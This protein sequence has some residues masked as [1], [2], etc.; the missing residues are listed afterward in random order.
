[1][2]ENMIKQ[3]MEKNL[4]GLYVTR[5]NENAIMDRIWENQKPHRK[6]SVGLVL[7]LVVMLAAVGALAAVLL[8]GKAF[9]GQI[10]APMATQTDSE[11]FTK[12]EVGRIIA[13][14]EENGVQLPDRIYEHYEKWGSEYKEELM[15]ALVKTELGF[16]PARWSLEDQHWYGQLLEECGLIE[17]SSNLLPG[18]GD[19]TEAYVENLAIQMITERLKPE[20]DLRDTTRYK[21]SMTYSLDTD[22]PYR[23]LKRWSVAYD[24][25][26][27]NGYY[28]FELLSNGLVVDLHRYG[29]GDTYQ[30][31]LSDWQLFED[32]QA[33]YGESMLDW[34]LEALEA[35][36]CAVAMGRGESIDDPGIYRVSNERFLLPGR[37]YTYMAEEEAIR[38]AREACGAEESLTPYVIYIG[39]GPSN[40]HWKISF[41]RGEGADR[42]FVCYAQLDGQTGEV[43]ARGDYAGKPWYA[44]LVRDECLPDV[45]P[46]VTTPKAKKLPTFWRSELL[47]LEYWETLEKL[48]YNEATWEALEAQWN[49]TYGDEAFW[50]L[51]CF[52]VKW[53]WQYDPDLAVSRYEIPGIPLSGDVDMQAAQSIAEKAYWQEAK[54]LFTPEEQAN[55]R[56]LPPSMYYIPKENGSW[57]REWVFSFQLHRGGA[58]YTENQVRVDAQTG[59]ILELEASDEVGNG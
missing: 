50:P 46:T 5:E 58:A 49:E 27:T 10:V 21:R 59:E 28:I 6:F 55:T 30:S 13:L 15:R 4:S 36:Y 7:A 37:V 51:E 16:Y 20:G 41:T 35:F 17:K 39:D 3:A 14:A 12:E 48:N 8:G 40:V 38:L 47:P 33:V 9:T 45:E 22:S 31:G 19:Y 29:P 2:G 44:P 18:E 11:M 24:D 53:W 54:A 23:T 57:Q 52:A 56:L 1:M 43:E 26:V 32:F 34:G 25:L 42:E